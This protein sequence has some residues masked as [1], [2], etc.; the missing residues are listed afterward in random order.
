MLIEAGANINS[1]DSSFKDLRTP[2]M[3]AA[4][5]GHVD[6]I[7]LLLDKGANPHLKDSKGNTYLDILQQ[8]EEEQEKLQ[9]ESIVNV[10]SIVLCGLV[11][12]GEVPRF[13]LSSHHSI[14]FTL[15][16]RSKPETLKSKSI[17]EVAGQELITE[18]LSLPHVTEPEVIATGIECFK[19]KHRSLAV[20]KV[21]DHLYCIHCAYNVKK[22]L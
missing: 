20:T 10:S 6:I 15:R 4:S 9:T 2:L 13:G 22:Y 21:L 16:Q 17:G 5:Q 1:L 3:K 12:S 19:C 7:S 11:G 14:P 18:S 8:H